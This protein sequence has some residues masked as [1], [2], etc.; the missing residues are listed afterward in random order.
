MIEALI[1]GRTDPEELADLAKRR[2]RAKIPQLQQALWGSVTDHHRF[3][4]R[5]LMD[6]LA[7]VEV[8]IG[9]FDARIEEAL[10]PFEEALARLATIPGVDRRA[11][12]VVLAEIGTDMGR[13]PTAGHLSS[14]AGMA[15][16]NDVS[17]G[18]RRT[19]RTPPGNVW[20]K[21]ILV[22]AAWAAS[23]K[24]GSHLSSKFRR[25]AAGRGRKRAAVAVGHAILVVIYHL[26]KEGTTY[27][28]IEVPP[29]AA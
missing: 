29:T 16:G 14:W 4:L 23:R 5:A 12:Q 26:L 7:E 24:Q 18:K 15:S 17:A 22:Q 11:A 27:R 19:G 20:L 3:M 8:M 1:R 2:L 21:S 25:I 28:E 9:R 6:Q 13:F 10:A